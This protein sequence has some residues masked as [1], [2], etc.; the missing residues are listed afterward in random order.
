MEVL[1]REKSFFNR[2]GMVIILIMTTNI[3]KCASPAVV[4]HQKL[5]VPGR[6]DDG[7]TA[8][9]LCSLVHVA[10]FCVPPSALSWLAA[11]AKGIGFSR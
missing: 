3:A 7:G 9:T 6:D 4:L 11:L 2:L 1:L 5:Y 10:F 8:G